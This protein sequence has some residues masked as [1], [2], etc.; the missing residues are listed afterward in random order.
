VKK[1]ITIS[2]IL[3]SILLISAEKP[4]LPWQIN[5]NW[6]TDTQK[7]LP[8]PPNKHITS[9]TNPPTP[10]FIYPDDPRYPTHEELVRISNSYPSN[11]TVIFIGDT[12]TTI[13]PYEEKIGI[14]FERV[15][16][17]LYKWKPY[18][19]TLQCIREECWSQICMPGGKGRTAFAT[20]ITEDGKMTFIFK[21]PIDEASA[22]KRYL[23][24]P[25][26][27]IVH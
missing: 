12:E 24:R 22:A 21:V 18:I 11:K 17:I 20:Y 3:S 23:S 14:P 15:R 8:F 19:L 10:N 2:M 7:L 1:I 27:V 6:Q 25:D 13:A 16:T 9:N 5:L 26:N 4:L